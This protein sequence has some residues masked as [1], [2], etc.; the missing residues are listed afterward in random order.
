MSAFKQLQWRLSSLQCLKYL[1]SGPLQKMFTD[2][3]C[4][5]QGGPSCLLLMACQV[6][7]SMGSDHH[8]LHHVPYMFI[9]WLV[10]P[11]FCYWFPFVWRNSDLPFHP[12]LLSL[13]FYFVSCYPKVL[14][15]KESLGRTQ[16]MGPMSLLLELVAQI[17]DFV[18]LTGP[19]SIWTGFSVG[20]Q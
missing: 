6:R 14:P 1:S 8:S 7:V 4:I 2:P 12:S 13:S 16:A 19:V 5:G 17:S 9:L 18:V 3:K 20:H 15:W 11:M 10:V